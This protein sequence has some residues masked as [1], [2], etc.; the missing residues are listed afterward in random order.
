[1]WYLHF[2][3]LAIHQLIDCVGHW[4][5]ERIIFL[6]FAFAFHRF[7][8]FIAFSLFAEHLMWIDQFFSSGF[9]RLHGFAHQMS[10]SL[11]LPHFAGKIQFEKDRSKHEGCIIYKLFD[12]VDLVVLFL[13]DFYFVSLIDLQSTHSNAFD[14]V[15][16]A[17]Y[18]W[19]R[20]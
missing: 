19:T 6:L 10:S 1:M 12:S 7:W 15:R 3:A 20:T 14:F 9:L 18:E 16:R 11:C 2:Y 17:P 4:W 13:F 8:I 5:T